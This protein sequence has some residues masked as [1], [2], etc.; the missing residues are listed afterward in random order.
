MTGYDLETTVHE[1]LANPVTRAILDQYLPG[2]ADHEW[3]RTTP[4]LRLGLIMRFTGSLTATAKQELVGVLANVDLVPYEAEAPEDP[5]PNVR[6]G[7]EPDEVV[8]GSAA[9]TG[10]DE[11][12]PFRTVELAYEGPSHGNPYLDVTFSATVMH[13]GTAVTWPGFYD[14]HGVWRVRFL[15]ETPGAYEVTTTSN[16]RS[17]DGIRSVVEVAPPVDGDHGPVRVEGWG[18]RHADGTRAIPL[19]TTCYAWTHQGDALE[20]QTLATLATAPWTKLRMCVF[21]KSM[22]Y[23]ANEPER[24]PYEPATDESTAI[25]TTRA[26]D[27]YDKQR[28]NPDYFQH[29]ERRIRQLADLGIDADLIVFHPY[30]RWG[31]ATLGGQADAHYVRYLV[32]R[33]AAFP[34]LWWS[35]ANEFD[36]MTKTDDDWHRLGRLVRDLDPAHHPIGIHNCGTFFDHTADWITHASVQKVDPYRTAEETTAWRERWG[37]PVVID[38]MSYEGDLPYGW[39]N[40]TAQEMVRRHWEAACRGGFGGHG[41]TYLDAEDVLWW[42]KGGVL[43]GESAARIGFLREVLEDAP[44]DIEPANGGDVVLGVSGDA[45]ALYYFTFM[46][47]RQGILRLPPGTWRLD[48]LDT[49]A[50]T[51]SPVAGT[52]S[53]EALVDL[54][55]RPYI[56]VRARRSDT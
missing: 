16:A 32:A 50:M 29:L 13:A 12:R 8:R 7:Y 2:I 38:E 3:V 51:V 10:P 28:F 56:A 21:P 27:R 30:D 49:W 42:A 48:V 46:Q 47:P 54:P 1:L 52:F 19:G 43:K 55:G 41:E 45:Y 11:A 25:G 36:L 33:L 17:L 53:G 15:P 39:G 40:I 26:G 4:G 34:N 9:V 6:D 31:Y 22:P 35:M 24:Y 14:G 37:K 23:N 5:W 20:E 44:G 18:F